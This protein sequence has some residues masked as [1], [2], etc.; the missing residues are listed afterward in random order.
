MPAP[1]KKTKN[2][3]IKSASEQVGP[4]LMAIPD[5]DIVRKKIT[6]YK[7]KSRRKILELIGTGPGRTDALDIICK[8]TEMMMV[9]AYALKEPLVIEGRIEGYFPGDLDLDFV[10]YF[11]RM[12]YIPYYQS[13]G[14][15]IGFHDGK[16][17][18]NNKDPNAGPEYANEMIA[19]FIHLGGINGLSIVNWRASDDTLFYLGTM[20][21]IANRF[22]T[23]D[24]YGKILKKNYFWVW[25]QMEGR[26]PGI[27]TSKS[28]EALKYIEWDKLKYDS[29]AIGNGA[30]MRTGCI[31]IVYPG[32]SNRQK[33]I[34]LA[35][36]ASRITHNSA[37]SILGSVT[38]AL[39]T[40]Y[41]VE[42]VPVPHWPHKLLKLL[43]AYP[44][45]IDLYM[46]NSRP[47]DYDAYMADKVLFVSQWENYVGFR[48]DGLVPRSNLIMMQKPV[49]RIKHLSERF[50]K[51]DK[52][53]PGACADDACI[54]AYDALLEAGD[55]LEKLLVYSI[56]HHGD[57]DT[58]GSI[59]FSWFG[60][61]YF[62]GPNYKLI[63]KR[64]VKLEFHA[65]I[66]GVMAIALENKFAKTYYYDLY[67]HFARKVIRKVI[68]S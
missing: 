31:G 15:T 48:F 50:S 42:R 25:D 54:I 29:S 65:R 53:N 16:W 39:F 18:F 43:K 40:A 12:I 22:K 3:S 37:I 13:L 47:A 19:E 45:K 36:E 46:K 32:S 8:R 55:N 1:N 28:M 64:I 66:E 4:Q 21:T 7:K 6:K 49:L 11:N 9:E 44:N 34:T 30:C 10:G 51:C 17:E 61:N 35:T 23:L 24:E 41:A 57:S 56:L 2:Q 33:L 20:N 58:I 59:A 38:T 52:N 67:M 5:W 68:E 14:D 26:A 62:S 63:E 27:Q 60:A